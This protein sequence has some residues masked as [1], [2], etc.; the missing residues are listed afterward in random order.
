MKRLIAVAALILAAAMPAKAQ[1]F[2]H[3]NLTPSNVQG[4]LV[5]GGMY[6]N[7]G[8][9]QVTELPIFYRNAAATDP[10]YVP[11][12]S[13]LTIGGSAG[14]GNTSGNAGSLLDVGPQ[15]ISGV[16][17]FV[18]LFS[19]NGKTSVSNFFNCSSSATACAALSTGVLANF[20]IEENGQFS[21]SLHELFRHPVGYFIG[22]SILFGGPGNASTS[23]R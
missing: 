13:P 17:G 5:V 16:E 23:R 11:S 7:A 19:A 3:A 4:E 8:W 2:Q 6:T 22:P 10:W 9:N 21:T 18:G 20:T 1:F 14:G 15:I 12:F